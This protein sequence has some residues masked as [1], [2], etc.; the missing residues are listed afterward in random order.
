L[1]SFLKSHI[2]YREHSVFITR[3]KLWSTSQRQ[4]VLEST[5]VPFI[6]H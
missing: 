5:K 4:T 6:P 3:S 1:N 2:S